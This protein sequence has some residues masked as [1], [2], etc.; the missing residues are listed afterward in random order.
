MN[1]SPRQLSVSHGPEEIDVLVIGAGQAGLAAG[2]YLART[3]LSFL[4]VDRHARIGDG[5][6]VA[7][8]P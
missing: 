4:I 5:G 7:T 6:A 2:H 8:I 3:E 1:R